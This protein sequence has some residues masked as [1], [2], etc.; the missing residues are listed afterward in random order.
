MR[1]AEATTRPRSGPEE[2]NRA[3][4]AY[5]AKWSGGCWAQ[6]ERQKELGF[7]S[8]EKAKLPLGRAAGLHG[9]QGGREKIAMF[10]SELQRTTHYSRRL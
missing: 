2:G 3:Y 6:E 5:R 1:W 9:L 10:F 8:L 4:G 7:F